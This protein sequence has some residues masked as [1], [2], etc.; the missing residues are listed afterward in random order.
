MILRY[1]GPWMMWPLF[2]IE[3]FIF[4]LYMCKTSTPI[5][6]IRLSSRIGRVFTRVGYLGSKSY[7]KKHDFVCSSPKQPYIKEELMYLLLQMFYIQ[8]NAECQ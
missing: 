7:H 5:C 8:N 1:V 6:A 3:H 4:E 2:L